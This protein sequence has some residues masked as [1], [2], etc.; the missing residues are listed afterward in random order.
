MCRKTIVCPTIKS[1]AAPSNTTV[2]YL[3]I[4]HSRLSDISLPL[5]R[6]VNAAAALCAN[7]NRP[8][9]IRYDLPGFTE[10]QS[11]SYLFISF[12]SSHF[13]VGYVLRR[14]S[15]DC[16]IV[17]LPEVAKG[18]NFFPSSC[19]ILLSIHELMIRGQTPHQMG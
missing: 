15:A 19:G 2:S 3:A 6:T 12:P 10:L 11:V 13:S 8:R 14:Y 4:A 18:I 1:P 7:S 16:S 5:E 17:L 9:R